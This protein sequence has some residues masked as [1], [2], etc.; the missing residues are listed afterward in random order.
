MHKIANQKPEEL[1]PGLKQNELLNRLALPNS[2]L[3]LLARM[4]AEEFINEQV[5][6]KGNTYE[7]EGKII[8]NTRLAPCKLPDSIR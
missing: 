3:D 1:F 6:S 2:I 5:S 8:P 7:S 4:L